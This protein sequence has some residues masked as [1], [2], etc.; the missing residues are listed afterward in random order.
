MNR[1]ARRRVSL[2]TVL[3]PFGVAIVLTAFASFGVSWS[4]FFAAHASWLAGMKDAVRVALEA[5]TYIAFGVPALILAASIWRFI[6]ARTGRGWIFLK[7]TAYLVLWAFGSSAL[8]GALLGAYLLA[9]PHA[10]IELLVPTAIGIVGYTLIGLGLL[11][12]AFRTT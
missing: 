1:V 7:A 5:S 4:G 6:F 10:P 11:A 9:G 12:S 8:L 3:V 2:A